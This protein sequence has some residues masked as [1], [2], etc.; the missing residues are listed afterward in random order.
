M[1]TGMISIIIPARNEPYLN[2]TILD[3]LEKATGKIEIIAVLDGYWPDEVLDD[4]RLHY[5][6]FSEPR[7]MRN[8]INMGVELAQ[9]EYILKTDAHCLFDEGF[10]TKLKADCLDNFV[11]VPRRSRL[12]P[13]TWAL[14]VDGRPPVDYEYIDSADLHGVRWE[15]RARLRHDI[16]IDDI[17]SAQGSCYFMKKDYYKELE[18]L[19]EESY[20]T[21]FLEFQEIAFKAWLSGGRVVV[22]KNT[23]YAHWHKTKGRGYSLSSEEREKALSFIANWRDGTAWR[24]QTL[25]FQSMIDRFMPMPTWI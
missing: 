17:I 8:A 19:D 9:G 3:L 20:G 22:N 25:P 10:D 12:D 4:A 2:K 5:I 16:M 15:E 21:F 11:V 1:T 14:I 7:G 6:H 23:W 13:E 24:K 18:L